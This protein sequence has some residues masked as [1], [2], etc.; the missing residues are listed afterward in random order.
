M[1]DEYQPRR[2][3]T[4]SEAF[5]ERERVAK[6]AGRHAA[7]D[8]MISELNKQRAQLL[9]KG[10]FVGSLPEYGPNSSMEDIA[11]ATTAMLKMGA[12]RSEIINPPTPAGKTGGSSKTWNG[13]MGERPEVFTA[14][15][16]A[17]GSASKA[18][19][20][21]VFGGFPGVAESMR[22]GKELMA[23]KAA[24]ATKVGE[25]RAA[26][27]ALTLTKQMRA[28]GTIAPDQVVNRNGAGWQALE[29]SASRPRMVSFS[30]SGADIMATK[31]ATPAE[32][33]ATLIAARPTAPQ[34]GTTVGVPERVYGDSLG[35]QRTGTNVLP[36]QNLL[37]TGTKNWDGSFSSINEDLSAR[38]ATNITDAT[39]QVVR[40]EALPNQYQRAGDA[41]PSAT[42]GNDA[43]ARAGGFRPPLASK[44][45][46][47]PTTG[48][49][50]QLAPKPPVPMPATS[51]ISGSSAVPS[52]ATKPA[53]P[54]FVGPITP[55]QS[56]ERDV[57]TAQQDQTAAAQADTAGQAKAI[58]QLSEELQ[59]KTNKQEA[60]R[61]RAKT[62]RPDPTRNFIDTGVYQP[63][64]TMGRPERQPAPVFGGFD[65]E[66]DRLAQSSMADAT[67]GTGAIRRRQVWNG[68][69]RF[70]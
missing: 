57:L 52:V 41:T 59:I 16:E 50:N 48:T 17:L 33:A 22:L 1:V 37:G 61:I 30:P 11:R 49:A 14:A 12:T 5:N 7:Q 9:Q 44:R 62:A 20:A 2:G 8:Q 21:G 29:Q 47:S 6:R 28:S 69:G 23:R 34:I 56:S 24:E 32:R 43:V 54:N 65:E 51:P 38:K 39:G 60:E 10:F 53:N 45:P 42:I 70:A 31:G 26:V 36:G 40:R 66:R 67:V 63:G 35:R 4:L 25:T 19:G 15:S 13:E 68:E 55:L 27:N 58:N 46:T 18:A 3:Q 64:V